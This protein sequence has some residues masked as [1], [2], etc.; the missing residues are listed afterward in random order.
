MGAAHI[1]SGTLWRIFHFQ[2]IY[3]DTLRRAESLSFH[4][5]PFIQHGI[6]LAQVNADILAQVALDHA[7][8]HIPFLF[9]VLV[10]DYASLFFPNLLKNYVLCI[11]GGNPPEFPGLDFH[12]EHVANL[13]PG[14]KLSCI[15]QGNLQAGVFHFLFRRHDLLLRIHQKIT[16]L[17]VNLDMHIVRLAK[18]ILAGSQ[19]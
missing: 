18:M 11:L 2:N 6:R 5:F 7:R 13:C 1:D 19:Q 8:H 12:M 9:I 10:I 16:G 14:G 15:V 4:L 3:L 17:P